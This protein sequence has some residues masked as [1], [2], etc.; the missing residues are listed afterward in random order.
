ME[1]IL[2][3]GVFCSQLNVLNVKSLTSAVTCI[4]ADVNLLNIKRKKKK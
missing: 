3:L 2:W 1:K 4:A